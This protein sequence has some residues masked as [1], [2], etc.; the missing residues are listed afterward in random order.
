V[1]QSIEQLW[2][3]LSVMGREVD[4]NSITTTIGVTPSRVFEIGDSKGA[5]AE[6][7]AGWAWTSGLTSETLE[8][9]LAE[10]AQIFGPHA[11]SFRTMAEVGASVLLTVHGEVFTDVIATRDEAV[12]RQWHVSVADDEFESFLDHQRVELYIDSDSN[13][14]L[15]KMGA[16]V[17]TYI[18]FNLNSND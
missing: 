18:V 12:R 15:G 4:P 8:A 10:F 6:D 7:K 2:L 11:Q 17:D 5:F 16:S 3:G 13:Q 1:A 14:L 9:P